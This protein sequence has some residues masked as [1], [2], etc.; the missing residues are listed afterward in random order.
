MVDVD[1]GVVN[2]CPPGCQNCKC[3]LC[4]SGY[5]SDSS[6]SSCLPCAEGCLSCNPAEI[7]ICYICQ[8]GL[9]LNATNNCQPCHVFCL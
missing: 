6:T 2:V 3:N 1:R 9:F 8:K 4:F 5:F 7:T